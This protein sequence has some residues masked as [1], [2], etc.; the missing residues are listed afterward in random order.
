MEDD[1]MSPMRQLVYRF[2]DLS[3]HERME[4]V[5]KLRLLRD[6]DRGLPEPK[7]LKRVFGRI[8]KEGLTDRFR[9]EIDAHLAGHA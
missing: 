8:N 3:Y 2:F 5:V 9:Q 7:L 4:I 1:S 6:E